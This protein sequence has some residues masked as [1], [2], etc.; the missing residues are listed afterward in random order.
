MYPFL[1]CTKSWVNLQAFEAKPYT[2]QFRF[3]ISLLG[4][5]NL[6]SQLCSAPCALTQAPTACWRASNHS[7][8]L[9]QS[10]WT[11]MTKPYLLLGS[12][13]TDS[14][15]PLW[16][17]WYLLQR[18]SALHWIWAPKI[19]LKWITLKDNTECFSLL[20]FTKYEEMRMPGQ[21]FSAVTHYG[22]RHSIFKLSSHFARWGLNQINITYISIWHDILD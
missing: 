19:Y 5:D 2:F 13:N 22:A 14:L 7:L 20:G 4:H 15:C 10:Y 1:L 9:C 3:D 6:L 11:N 21:S 16:S 17:F 12:D 8:T 18:I